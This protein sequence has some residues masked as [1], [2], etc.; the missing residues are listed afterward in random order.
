MD[1]FTA[2]VCVWLKRDLRV[3]DHPALAA[4]VAR[5]SGAAVFVVFL[6]EPE[7][8]AQPEWHP[9]HTEFQR[10]C[11]VELE[12]ALGRLGIRLVTRRGE[13]VAMLDRLRHE[14]GF[15]LREHL[16]LVEKHHEDGRPAGTRHGRRE[17]GMV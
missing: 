9:S 8:L 16:G 17:R 13:A 6:Y 7:V 11:L 5:A 14:T 3:A 2:P 15:R 4:A 1:D 12:A 10:A